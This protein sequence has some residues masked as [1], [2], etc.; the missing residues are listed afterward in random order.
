MNPPHWRAVITGASGGI[1]G[2]I[3]AALAARC[4]ALR[5]VGRDAAR[6][7]SRSAALRAAHP[8][9]DARAVVADVTRAAGRARVV[10]ATCEMNGANLLV[11]SAGV[12]DFS[13]FEAQPEAALESMVTTNLLAPMLLTRAL[14]PLLRARPA[15]RIVNVGSILGYLGYPGCVAY[16]ASKFG[17]RGFSEALRRELADTGVGVQYFA[18]R[19]TRTALN[20][21]A[22]CRLNAEL[23]VA[24]DTP[25]QVAQ[26]FLAL[27][28][29]PQ[30][31]ES[32]VGFPE[33]LFARLNQLLPGLVDGS[34][35]KQLPLIRKY[36]G[37]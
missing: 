2:A 13:L 3:A 10:E 35:R 28:D 22:M 23:K 11:N 16:S 36:A 30:R 8:S 33:K 18:P 20:S 29:T 31:A 19:A 15:A 6:L 34:L 37:K 24:V 21:D 5:L 25:E 27:L 12:S 9:L 14:L 4:T 26:E 17:L 1:G 7:E 32:R